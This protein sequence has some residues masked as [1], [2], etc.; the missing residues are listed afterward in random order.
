MNSGFPDTH[1]EKKRKIKLKKRS[2]KL[3]EIKFY[4]VK[5]GVSGKLKKKNKELLSIERIRKDENKGGVGEES[6]K[7]VK[8]GKI[9]ER[10]TN[11]RKGKLESNQEREKLMRVWE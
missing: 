11:R 2:I 5:R 9:T 3:R 4:K 1:K 10:Q 7:C 6:Q 8:R